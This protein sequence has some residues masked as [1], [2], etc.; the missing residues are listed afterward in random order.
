MAGLLARARTKGYSLWS[1]ARMNYFRRF[2][3][4]DIGERVRMSS[5]VRLDKTNPRGIHIGDGT[6]VSFETA[7]LTHD[8]VN[9]EHRD[10]YVGSYCFVGAKS[11]VM[12]GVRIGD[13]CIIGSGSVVTADIPSNSVAVG[14]PARVIKSGIRTVRWGMFLHAFKTQEELDRDPAGEG[15]GFKVLSPAEREELTI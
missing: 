11:I 3:G 15:T 9:G 10:T 4:M 2:W 8:F 13:H 12:P 6:L 7:I 5:S 14:N 1:S